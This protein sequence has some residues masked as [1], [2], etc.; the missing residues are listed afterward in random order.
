MWDIIPAVLFGEA[1]IAELASWLRKTGSKTYHRSWKTLLRAGNPK[2]KSKHTLIV[3]S[4]RA[5]TTRNAS[6]QSRVNHLVMR[7][8]NFN[9]EIGPVL[10][11][12]L[13]CAFWWSELL[14]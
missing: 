6:T 4:H 12:I 13:R 10:F 5:V 2:Q 1:A 7:L 3:S 8:R 14:R 9:G 11:A